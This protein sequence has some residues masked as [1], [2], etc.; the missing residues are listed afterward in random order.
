MKV[1]VCGIKTP[2]DALMCVHYGA[3]AVGLLVGQSH[4]SND[5]I[6]KE[7]ARKIVECL[8]PFCSSVLVT[9]LENADEI[10][11]LTKFI[12]NTTIQL[13]SP[14]IET[15]VEKIHESLPWVKLV[16]LVHVATDGTIT[17]DYSAF[18]YTDAYLLDSFNLVTNQVGGTGLTHDWNTSAKIV[19]MVDKPV[20]LAGGLNPENIAEAIKTVAPWGVDINSGLKNSEG[21]KDEQKVKRFITAAKSGICS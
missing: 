8:P 7:Q 1:K 17:T 14:I 5:F 16:R 10:I 19:R 11:S 2:Q 12:G 21:F 15:E 18:Q 3:D 9:H 6:T 13:H 4:A 20:I